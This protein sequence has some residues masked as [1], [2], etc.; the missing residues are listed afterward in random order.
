MSI[1]V[2]K[3]RRDNYEEERENQFLQFSREMKQA[4]T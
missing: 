1:D 2:T 4:T 3:T